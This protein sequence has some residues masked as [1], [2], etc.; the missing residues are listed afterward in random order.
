MESTSKLTDYCWDANAIGLG[1]VI[2]QNF[3]NAIRL[4]LLST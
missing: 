3:L 2:G 1:L 4:A